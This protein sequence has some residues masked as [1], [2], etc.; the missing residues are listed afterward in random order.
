LDPLPPGKPVERTARDDVADDV[1]AAYVVGY[2]DGITLLHSDGHDDPLERTYARYLCNVELEHPTPG[3]HAS[4]TPLRTTCLPRLTRL[5]RRS[6]AS[7]RDRRTNTPL[8]LRSR[9]T[10]SS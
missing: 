1:A 8:L 7:R 4:A 9:D 6:T 5:S 10:V 3:K 2:S